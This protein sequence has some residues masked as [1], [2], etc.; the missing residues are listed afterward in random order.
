[1]THRVSGNSD[2]RNGRGRLLEDTHK[3]NADRKDHIRLKRYSFSDHL[4]VPI[5]PVLSRQTDYREILSF[6]VAK[7]TQFS[8]KCCILWERPSLIEFGCLQGEVQNDKAIRLL[9]LLRMRAR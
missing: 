5:S 2:H 7:P 4:W 1:M 6:I 9:T 3:P 8:E